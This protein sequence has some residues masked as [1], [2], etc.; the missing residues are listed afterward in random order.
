IANY[1]NEHFSAKPLEQIRQELWEHLN[2][3]KLTFRQIVR[4]VL[5]F[6]QEAWQPEASSMDFVLSGEYHLLAADASADLN[7]LRQLFDAINQKRQM[8]Y[9]LDQCLAADGVKIF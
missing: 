2:N 8:L 9:L 4:S 1:F 3:E 6:A 5:D 7:R